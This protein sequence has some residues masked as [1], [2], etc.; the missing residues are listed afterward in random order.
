MSTRKN[1]ALQGKLS[2]ATDT[3]IACTNPYGELLISWSDLSPATIQ[4]LGEFYAG[5][6]APAEARRTRHTRSVPLRVVSTST[7][8]TPIGV[9]DLDAAFATHRRELTAKHA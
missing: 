1:V 3:E 4:K 5:A 8:V 7:D 9:D 2:R 6:F